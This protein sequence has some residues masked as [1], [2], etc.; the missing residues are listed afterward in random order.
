MANFNYISIAVSDKDHSD[1]TIMMNLLNILCDVL[2]LPKNQKSMAIAQD[3][4]TLTPVNNC[5]GST[6]GVEAGSTWWLCVQSGKN[7]LGDNIAQA[8]AKLEKAEDAK[9]GQTLIGQITEYAG[10]WADEW[11]IEDATPPEPIA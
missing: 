10:A 4:F 3:L 6:H 9:I 1:P 8:Q 7:I 5:V 2:G 11:G